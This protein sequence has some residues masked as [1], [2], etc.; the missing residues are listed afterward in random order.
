MELSRM[1]AVIFSKW[2]CRMKGKIS[3][4][5]LILL[6]ISALG[7]YVSAQSKPSEE[8]NAPNGAFDTQGH[9]I[10]PYMSFV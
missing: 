7:I 5:L 10:G 4:A 9:P 3:L 8:Q 6:V 2:G 1:S